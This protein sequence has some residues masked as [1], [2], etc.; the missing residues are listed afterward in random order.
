MPPL[1]VFATDTFYWCTDSHEK[2]PLTA[3]SFPVHTTK[4]RIDYFL[5]NPSEVKEVY[6]EALQ[7]AMQKYKER[8]THLVDY[9]LY[10]MPDVNWSECSID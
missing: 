10:D 5:K 2:V 4:E 7:I 6:P 1:F 9:Y 8:V 3:G